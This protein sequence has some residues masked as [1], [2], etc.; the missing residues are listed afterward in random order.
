M[1][2]DRR[3][4]VSARPRRRWPSPTGTAGSVRVRTTRSTWPRPAATTRRGAENRRARGGDF[5][6]AVDAW[7]DC[8]QVHGD[9][10]RRRSRRRRRRRRPTR[11]P[12]DALVTDQ[13]GVGADGPGRRLRAGAARRRRRPAWSAPP[14]PAAPGWSPASSP[15]HR[16]AM[17]DLG[18]AAI[19]G[20]GRAARVRP[21]L[22][23]ARA[24]ARRGRGRRARQPCA[25]DLVGHAVARHRRRRA[26]PA[27]RA[28]ASRSS[29]SSR[30]TRET[31]DLFS[32]R[33]DGAARPAGWPAL[34]RM[35]AVS[36][37]PR[38]DR[39]RTSTPCAA[40]SP[41]RLRRRRPRPGRGDAGR[42]HQVL[43]G[44]R[45]PAAGRPR[46]HRRGGEPPPGGRGQGAPSAPTSACAGTSSAGCRATRRPPSRRT[47]T[48]SSRST[49][50][51][52]RRPRST[53]AP[54]S[55]AAS[56]RR[57]APGEPRP[58]RARRG[59]A[60]AD[61]GRRSPALAGAVDG[62]R[63]AAAARADGGGAARRGPRARRSRGWPRSA[64][65][66]VAGHPDADLAVG[67]DER[68]PRGRRRGRRDTR[69]CRLARS[70]V[71]G[72]AIK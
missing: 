16:R 11:P 37:P 59:R 23:G 22:R 54:T 72:P 42:G 68:R 71:R 20:L 30:C 46:R 63:G 1:Y 36:A 26:R 65:T 28:P 44:L 66:F 8:S 27:R 70:S 48:S 69:A 64:P 49:G 56:R 21:L 14:T 3:T 52:L 13:P 50:A 4:A 43:P 57:A 25:D 40:G 58:A 62:G 10:V 47:P 34:V 41:A 2:V 51:K 12:R 67:R 55:A 45:R 29:T 32:Y 6:P 39:R 18:A 17:R 60:G 31:P 53:A 15:A 33:R 7:R 9:D 24:D 61:A 38:R 35:R 5:A 19:D